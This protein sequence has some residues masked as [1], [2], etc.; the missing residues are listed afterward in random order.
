MSDPQMKQANAFTGGVR[1]NLTGAAAMHSRAV[2]RTC[3][4][5]ARPP[6]KIMSF[7]NFSPPQKKERTNSLCC[8]YY[9]A[10]SSASSTFTLWLKMGECLT[11][12]RCVRMQVMAKATVR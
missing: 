11:S 4:V 1:V 8:C 12:W 6:H 2:Q 7:A 3:D 9:C 10:L 5:R